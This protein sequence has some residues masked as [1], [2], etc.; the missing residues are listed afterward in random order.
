MVL[1]V[2]LTPAYSMDPCLTMSDT[3][4]PKDCRG[5]ARR[6]GEGHPAPVHR[7][8]RVVGGDRDVELVGEVRAEARGL[9]RAAGD[10]VRVNPWLWNAPMSGLG[11]SS[12][13][14]R[15]SVV[16]PLTAVPAP[17]AALPGSRARVWVGPP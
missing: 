4:S 2:A 10:G 13:S 12:G 16:T 17:M 1:A 8:D 11:L 7:L 6:D 14:P 9:R 15:W 5:A 3:E